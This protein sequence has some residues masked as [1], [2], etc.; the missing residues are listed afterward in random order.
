MFVTLNM[1]HLNALFRVSIKYTLIALLLISCNSKE[2]ENN[3]QLNIS[4]QYSPQG[5]EGKLISKYLGEEIIELKENK[6][7]IEI[8]VYKWLGVPIETYNGRCELKS[9]TLFLRYWEEIQK[10]NIDLPHA[11]LVL[12]SKLVYKIKKVNYKSIVV[13]KDTIHVK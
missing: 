11:A 13:L 8:D 12:K 9:D 2:A 1:N 4:F 10:A 7:T 6:D 5:G 3:D